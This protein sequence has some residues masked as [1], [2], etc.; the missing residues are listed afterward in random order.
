MSVT[1]TLTSPLPASHKLRE[2]HHWVNAQTLTGTSGRFGD[3]YNPASGEL[4]ASVAF[5]TPAE[6][7]TAVAAAA[8]AFPH[9]AS[10]PP[11]RRARV[12]FRFRELCERRLD[13]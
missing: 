8:A 6:G 2:V 7:D 9:W 3:V 11:R 4:Q 5:A 13:G 12:L 10:Q 1:S